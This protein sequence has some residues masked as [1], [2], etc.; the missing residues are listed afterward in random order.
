MYRHR[1]TI[2][3]S[4]GLAVLTVAAFAQV[5]RC[6]F[7]NYDDATYVSDNPDVTAGLNLEGVC[8]AF[9]TTHASNWH[10]LT[11]L[12]LQLDASL[13]G[14]NPAGY[15]V[16]NLLLHLA[17]VVLL[18]LFLS[19]A[20]GAVW[21]SAAVAAFFAVHP[22]RVES[23]A[24]V[25]ERKDV[26]SG[27][28]WMLTLIAYLHHARRPGVGRYLL[29]VLAFA[30]GL[31][32]KAML[33]TLPFVLALL[34]YWPL[35]RLPWGPTR[36]GPLSALAGNLRA[37][38]V[39]LR[40]LV[41][42]KVPLLLLAI[43]TAAATI[44]AQSTGVVNLEELPLHIRVA[45]ALIAYV[46]YLLQVFWLANLRVLYPHPYAAVSWWQSAAA[47]IVV[48]TV[49][50]FAL[51]E[52]RRR[53][54][55]LVGWCWY[56]GTLVPVVGLI[57]V[58]LQAHADRY[59]YL[60]L[61]GIFVMLVWGIPDLLQRWRFGR[62]VL[63]L[64]AALLLAA[65]VGLTALQVRYWKDTRTLWEH[66]LAVDPNNAFAHT[67]LARY[68][69]HKNQLDEA[70]TQLRKAVACEPKSVSFRARLVYVLRQAKRNQEADEEERQIGQ[71]ASDPTV[72]AP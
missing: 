63:P 46:T 12:S 58:G 17:S 51:R 21:R 62:V 55:L 28:F 23:V 37:P 40:L 66:V 59:T 45:N 13:Y 24:W 43:A 11:W 25:A 9:T 7:V 26:L 2:A 64:F 52:G 32:A 6:D 67:E 29:V 54:Y 42:E 56:L 36:E 39:S 50:V 47:A 48:L 68:L 16:T 14:L 49:S 57:Q 61:V 71:L 22:L 3:I 15:H 30:L 4:L 18:F 44:A 34:D 8:W 10:P 65:C 27:F 35:A 60:P 38:R 70:I 5:V 72:A 20:T 33:V 53:P 31:L 1:R 69:I 41:W 19:S